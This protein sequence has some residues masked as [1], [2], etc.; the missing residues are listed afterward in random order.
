MISGR[1]TEIMDERKEKLKL[2]LAI[3]II[4]I[5]IPKTTVD[6]LKYTIHTNQKEK[7]V[8]YHSVWK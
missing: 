7:H 1:T 3:I 6:K 8:Q 4:I 2:K 5:I